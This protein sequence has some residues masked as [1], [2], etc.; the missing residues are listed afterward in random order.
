MVALEEYDVV[1]SLARDQQIDDLPGVWATINIVTEEDLEHFG[2]RS[3]LSVIIYTVEN[4]VLR[5]RRSRECRPQRRYADRQGRGAS[6]S[7]QPGST[8][9]P[10][11]SPGP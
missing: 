5:D 2:G 7:P 11:H 10:R 8:V 4:I 9:S 6:A 1:F 3:R